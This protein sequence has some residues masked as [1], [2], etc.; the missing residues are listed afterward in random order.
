ML[1]HRNFKEKPLKSGRDNKIFDHLTVPVVPSHM[2]T[3]NLITA[4]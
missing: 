1:N 4:I 3:G 2:I